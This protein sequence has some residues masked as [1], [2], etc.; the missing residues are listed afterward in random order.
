MGRLVELVGGHHPVDEAPV[1]GRAGVDRVA[2]EGHLEG[3][4]AAHVAGHGDQRG[5]A[6]QSA[7]ATGDGEGGV[8]GRHRQIARRHQLATGGGGEGVDLGAHRLGDVLH[9]VHHLGAHGEEVAGL[10]Q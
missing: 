7:L 10:L 3:A 9:G 5:V 1:G 8:L 2:G 6:E 4:L